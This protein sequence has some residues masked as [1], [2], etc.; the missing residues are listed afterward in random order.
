M[1]DEFANE[2]SQLFVPSRSKYIDTV[3][4]GILHASTM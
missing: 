2:N 1:Y 3:A 4:K